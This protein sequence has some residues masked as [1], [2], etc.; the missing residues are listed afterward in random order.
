MKKGVPDCAKI[1]VSQF[2]QCGGSQNIF[3]HGADT[4]QKDGMKAAD[5]Y[6]CHTM[7]ILLDSIPAALQRG[8]KNTYV[9]YNEP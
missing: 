9:P 3:L 7:N 4:G 1:H 6:S 2:L 5:S 8:E